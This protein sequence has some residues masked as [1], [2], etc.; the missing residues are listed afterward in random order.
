MVELPQSS[1]IA[2]CRKCWKQISETQ[3]LSTRRK[4]RL[5]FDSYFYFSDLWYDIP[6][7]SLKNIWSKKVP[8]TSGRHPCSLKGDS[9]IFFPVLPA[10]MDFSPTFRSWGVQEAAVERRRKSSIAGEQVC[11]WFSG[12]KPEPLHIQSL[13]CYNAGRSFLWG[14]WTGSITGWLADCFSS[15]EANGRRLLAACELL[16]RFW[17]LMRIRV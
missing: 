14:W 4:G 3:Q 10:N 7:L 1:E 8:C 15:V 16:S 2:Y 9:R 17:N 5:S 12:S 6:A 11:W 13:L